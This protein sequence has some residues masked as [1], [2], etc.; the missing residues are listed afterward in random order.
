MRMCP[1]I[2]Y[3]FLY[4]LLTNLSLQAA[5]YVSTAFSQRVHQNIEE[6]V[7]PLPITYE[8]MNNIVQIIKRRNL[9]EEDEISFT[10]MYEA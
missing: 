8:E 10:K 9:S 5:I 3:I 4:N 1:C 2:K 6:K 7:Y